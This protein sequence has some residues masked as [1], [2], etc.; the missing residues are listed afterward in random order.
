VRRFAR[1]LPAPG[2]V[3][4]GDVADGRLRST[5]CRIGSHAAIPDYSDWRNSP[6]G[7]G[8]F[9]SR[10]SCCGTE[11]VKFARSKWLKRDASGVS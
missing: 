1:W 4:G 10:C 9:V 8:F 7:R 5:L 11:M 3:V 6:S 2:G